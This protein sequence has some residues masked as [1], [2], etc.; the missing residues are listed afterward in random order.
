[1]TSRWTKPRG[2]RSG[3]RG[4][5]RARP[6][7]PGR[8]TAG[9]AA[10]EDGPQAAA[11]QVLG[12]QERQVVLAP[13]V[14]GHEVGVVERGRGLGLGLEAA[15]ERGVV[16][17]RRVQ[18][19]DRDPPAE[20]DV[21]GQVD[22]G[23]RRRRP[24]ARSAGTAQPAPGR[25]AR[26]PVR[27]SHGRDGT[28][29]PLAEP[30]MPPGH[31][32]AG[33]PAAEPAG[34]RLQHTG[35]MSSA[36]PAARRLVLPA[37]GLVGL[38]LIVA[39]GFLAGDGRRAAGRP[40]RARGDLPHSTGPRSW[41]RTGSAPTSR[42]GYAGELVVNGVDDPRRTSSTRTTGS[43]SWCSTRARARCS[44]RCSRTG[45]APRS[46]CGAVEEGRDSAGPPRRWC[47]E[48]AV[49]AA[50]DSTWRRRERTQSA[51]ASSPAG[52]DRAAARSRAGA[53]SRP[54]RGSGT[55]S[56][57]ALVSLEAPGSAP[58]TTAVVFFETLPGDLPPRALMASS[59][60]SRL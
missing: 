57:V 47:F 35:A 54:R 39:A 12:D 42:P 31:E 32:P 37:L 16:G 44:P 40:A 18:H 27:E 29:R 9:R 60:S 38:A 22:L 2:G 45:T 50:A 48:R 30:W 24:P 7:A 53:R 26:S 46:C 52:R 51:V 10:V 6:P 36:A 3:G 49:S 20:L 19:L 14:D 43:T 13:V 28:D 56:S 15:Q 34:D 23:R 17:Q 33:T 5:P 21:V 41:P 1:M 4:R 59:A 8:P 25:R 55:P 11:L 58:T